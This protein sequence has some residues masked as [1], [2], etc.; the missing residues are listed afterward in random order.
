MIKT[1]LGYQNLDLTN[2]INER[3]V[4]L[5]PKG[6][7]SGGDVVAVPLQLQVTLSPWKVINKDGMVAEETS[8]TSVLDCPAG[9]E[10]VIAVKVI[11]FP[12]N[13]PIVEVVTYE[14]TLFDNLPDIDDHIVFAVVNVP[15]GASQVLADNISLQ[16]RD[17][18]DK[19]GRSPFRGVISN[20]SLLP[21]KEI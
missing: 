17:I 3:F 20:A 2:D 6:I 8:D 9:Q 7:F 14:K 21:Q 12:N 1:L 10:T 18:I 13:Q 5:I 15:V 4:D 11:Y 16:D 19:L